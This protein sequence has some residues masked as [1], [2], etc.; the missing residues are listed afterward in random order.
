[1]PRPMAPPKVHL[2]TLQMKDVN[3]LIFYPQILAS[4]S[5]TNE[6]TSQFIGICFITLLPLHT[7]DLKLNSFSKHSI[8]FPDMDKNQP[9]V[10]F[11][12]FFLI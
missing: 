6:G 12:F 2:E 4:L 11:F 3:N 5:V 7:S 9:L 1:M 10:P 8:V